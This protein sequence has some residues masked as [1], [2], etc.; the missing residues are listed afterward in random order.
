MK[1]YRHGIFSFQQAS[2]TASQGIVDEN[3]EFGL[4]DSILGWIHKLLN[5]HIHEV[6]TA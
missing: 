1:S 6:L 4:G 3:D 5:D 2:V